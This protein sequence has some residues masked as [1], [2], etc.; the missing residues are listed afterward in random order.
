MIEQ[1]TTHFR[2]AFLFFFIT[3]S[4][5]DVAIAKTHVRKHGV[6]ILFKVDASG[7]TPVELAFTKKSELVGAAFVTLLQQHIQSLEVGKS[8][9]SVIPSIAEVAEEK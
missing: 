1:S 6:Q 3:S 2:S 7:K 5:D 9:I 8:Y 4:L